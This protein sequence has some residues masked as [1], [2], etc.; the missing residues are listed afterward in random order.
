MKQN[1]VKFLV[2]S[3]RL[4]IRYSLL[5]IFLSNKYCLDYYV[6]LDTTAKALEY[7]IF[8]AM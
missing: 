3:N 8:T 2:S 5:C 4:N 7:D 6:K 1:F